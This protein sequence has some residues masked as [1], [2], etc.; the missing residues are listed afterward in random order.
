MLGISWS[1]FFS[2]LFFFFGIWD[3]ILLLHLLPLR[4]VF[5]FVLLFFSATDAA[6]MFQRKRAKAEKGIGGAST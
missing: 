1:V 3:C 4:T 6:H 2:L 5:Q